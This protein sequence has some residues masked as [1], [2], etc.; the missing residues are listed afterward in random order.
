ML[1]PTEVIIMIVRHAIL[2]TAVLLICAQNTS[3]FPFEKFTNSL[4]T[5]ILN[6]KLT[7]VTNWEKERVPLASTEALRKNI[8]EFFSKPRNHEQ[9][10]DHKTVVMMKLAKTFKKYGLFTE[11][12]AFP[13]TIAGDEDKDTELY[14]MNVV[15]ILQGHNW[16]T[17]ED[18]ITIIG[19]HYDTYLDSSGVDDGGS[20][21]SAM[22][23]VARVMTA[24]CKLNNS[25]MFA[26]FDLEEYGLLGSN[27]FVNR[28]FIPQYLLNSR[29]TL[30]GAFIIDSV[31]NFNENEFSQSITEE[32]EKAAPEVVLDIM[33][34]SQRGDFLQVVSREGFDDKTSE[35]YRRNW[36]SLDNPSMK[37][38]EIVL[39]ETDSKLMAFMLKD[40]PS[41]V[42]SDHSNFWLHN[43]LE[44][45]ESLPAVF[46]SDSGPF[47]EKMKKC[48]HNDCD[49]LSM[50]TEKNMRFL[51]KTTDT[52]IKTVLSL[53]EGM[54]GLI[55][56]RND[57][58]RQPLMDKA[59]TNLVPPQ[60]DI[61]NKM[62]DKDRSELNLSESSSRKYKREAKE[63][64]DDS[65]SL[66]KS[67]KK[68]KL[69]QMSLASYLS[70]LEGPQA[71]TATLN[72]AQPAQPTSFAIQ[73]NYILPANA[74][75]AQ[76]PGTVALSATQ[77]QS[78]RMPNS[79]NSAPLHQINPS[80]VQINPTS[81]SFASSPLQS[82]SPS[83]LAS[84]LANSAQAA[85]ATIGNVNSAINPLLQQAQLNP[86]R[87]ITVPAG[88]LLAKNAYA[89]FMNS[90][91][92]FLPFRG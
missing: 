48:D 74:I 73:G 47:R 22:L 40:Y 51:K 54:C 55:K 87:R 10:A 30:Q 85:Q 1:G 17:S 4:E 6:T 90:F 5:R 37:I 70:A 69:R 64:N 52:L 84:L 8:E 58:V 29:G 38:K 78:D 43:H 36:E 65:K 75:L 62:A 24:Q 88:L 32:L 92:R 35:I 86:Q 2:F 19:S 77:Q 25:I 59:K 57:K 18:Q 61:M 89:T 50:L 9:D 28:Y 81:Q 45:L 83:S 46:I 67:G 27:F 34:N 16:G 91:G 31:L 68:S 49:G 13:A 44:K 7:T 72:Q 66:K 3:S 14:G 63:T 80:Q 39:P 26:A 53:G 12:Q 82:A 33:K 20:G 42:R 41:L 60:Q 11:I 15:G 71:N 79:Q 56:R 23:E 76:P 21:V